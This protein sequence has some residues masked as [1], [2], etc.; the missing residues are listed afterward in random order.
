MFPRRSCSSSW[1]V[2]PVGSS[3]VT[4]GD[5]PEARFLSTPRDAVV[6]MKVGMA[7]LELAGVVADIHSVQA[8]VWTVALYGCIR[9][10]RA[11]RMDDTRPL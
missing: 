3:P 1:P 6:G 11:V 9:P 2:Y 4:C 8:V 5:S 10:V 7:G